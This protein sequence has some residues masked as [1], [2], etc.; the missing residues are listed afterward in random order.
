M[1]SPLRSTR[2]RS[3]RLGTI[4]LAVLITL[5]LLEMWV[6]YHQP[7]PR[8]QMVRSIYC[9]HTVDGVPIWG[10]ENE[11]DRSARRNR[12]CAEQHPERIRI[13][14]F[15]SSITYGSALPASDA[16]TTA[17]EA[18]LN[19]LRPTPGFCVM[20]FAE[21]GF[22][23]EQKYAVARVEVPRYKPALIMWEDWAEWFDYSMIGDTA[24]GTT[25]L[26]VRPDGFI[27]LA[28]VPDWLNRTLFLHSRLYEYLTLV[29]AE[30]LV[31]E[32]VSGPPE[33]ATATKFVN[34]RLIKVPQLAQ[35]VGA[36]LVFYLAPALNKS[37]SES[38]TSP[39][40]WHPPLL[41]FAR[42]HGIPAYALQHELLDQ[43][44]L[45]IR[46]DD[47]CHYNAAGH[48]ALV[49]IMARIILEQLDE[50]SAT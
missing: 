42:A 9:L 15:G 40:D 41:E 50:K 33:A 13:L 47:C 30:Q 24:Y 29:F 19:E 25:G 3:Y 5:G 38:E 45:A 43:D 36:K 7:W 49:P 11:R 23:F 46:M 32:Q 31:P 28:Y 44:Y 34:Q 21:P 10:C 2:P 27:G 37:F 1:P 4:V 26:R 8:R 48:R 39:P 16:F 18:R 22:S 12:E 14:F 17:L 35:S 6:R 20:N